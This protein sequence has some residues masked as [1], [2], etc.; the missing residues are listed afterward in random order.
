MATRAGGGVTVSVQGDKQLIARLKKLRT[1]DAN[2]M[3][4]KGLRAGA[5][6]VQRA[7]VAQS[8]VGPGRK[9]RK[10]GTLKRSFK[11]RAMKRKLGRIGILVQSGKGFFKGETFYSGFVVLGHKVGSRTLGNA[12]SQVAAN[13]FMKRAADKS[14]PEAI[15]ILEETVKRELDAMKTTAT[16]KK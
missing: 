3:I 1:T 13:E 7:T 2:K 5:K 6:V 12:R 15:R 8:P 11:V 16:I 14:A 4:R 10:P 9:D